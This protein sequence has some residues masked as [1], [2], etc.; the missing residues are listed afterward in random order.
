MKNNLNKQKET[1]LNN[2]QYV[3]ELMKIYSQYIDSDYAAWSKN[4]MRNQ[5]DFLGIRTPIRRKITKQYFKE[6]GVP[7]KESLQ[8]VIFELWDLPEREYQKAALDLLEVVKKTLSAEDM[9]WL[10]T[11]IVKKSWWDTVDVLSPHIAGYMFKAY[12]KLIPQY[13]DQWILDENI[14]LQRAAILYQLFFKKSTDEKRLFQYILA[15]ADSKEFFVQK[16]IGWV[17]REYAKTNPS[18]VEEFV[19]SSDLQPLSKREALKNL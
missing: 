8:Q 1:E 10:T 6:Y 9:S 14:W 11:L 12:P 13:A 18:I 17:L 2:E 4:Y 15:R 7:T 5:F 16:A 19:N 3:E